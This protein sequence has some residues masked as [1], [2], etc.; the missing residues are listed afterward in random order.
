M[1]HCDLAVWSVLEV[2]V[3]GIFLDDS[4]ALIIKNHRYKGPTDI[5][6]CPTDIRTHILNIMIMNSIRICLRVWILD[7]YLLYI[8][9]LDTNDFELLL[10][11]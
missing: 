6:M 4:E 5:Y 11:Q 7:V 2:T 3:F 10:L 9:L 8:K 1:T